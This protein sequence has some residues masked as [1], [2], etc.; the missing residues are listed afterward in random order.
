MTSLPSF[1]TSDKIFSIRYNS[2]MNGIN[3]Y[4]PRLKYSGKEREGYT[5]H[6]YFGARYY[7]NSTFRFI[8][9]DPIINKKEALVNPQLWNL[10]SY[11][12]N[13]PISFFDPDG[14]K[15]KPFN[16]NTDKSISTKPGTATPKFIWNK[17]AGGMVI[18]TEAYNCHSYAWHDSK[19]DPTDTRNALPLSLGVAGW[20][21]NPDDDM[22]GH[23]QISQKKANMKGDR[24]IYYI[25]ANNNKKWNK[26]EFIAHSAIVN[27]VDKEGYTTTVVGKMG[28][29]G[30][31]VNHPNAPN[32][33]GTFQG[34]TT[35]RAY[36]RKK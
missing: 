5:K 30:I 15:D 31:S 8:S 11:C 36:F 4:D 12:G 22:G 32:Y 29:R 16:P 19:G 34:N 28:F 20:D 10:Y 13:N 17:E 9:V 24:I 27:S 14:M 1:H 3:T 6:D 2:N 35:S 25:D 33:Y 23:K 18:N 7:D 21:D 26:G